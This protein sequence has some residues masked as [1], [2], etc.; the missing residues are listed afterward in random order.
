MLSLS[1]FYS[2]SLH[3]EGDHPYSFPSSVLSS[4]S[5]LVRERERGGERGDVSDAS[6]PSY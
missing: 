5:A 3:Y 4:L 6:L 2:H 1:L